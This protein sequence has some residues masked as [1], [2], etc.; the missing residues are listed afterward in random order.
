M[1][2]YDR[3]YVLSLNK[4]GVVKDFWTELHQIHLNSNKDSWGWHLCGEGEYSVASLR[5]ALDV[6]ALPIMPVIMKWNKYVPIKVN[7]LIRRI[8]MD[9]LPTRVNLSRK[10]IDI[11]S[12]RCLMCDDQLKYNDHVFFQCEIAKQV[13]H[14]TLMW[15]GLPNFDFNNIL[16]A[17]VGSKACMSDKIRRR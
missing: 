9:R 3:L 1:M 11:P 4:E 13:W 5:Q 2:K 17:Q 15:L 6:G 16:E 8:V 10:G 7:I 12:I 14:W